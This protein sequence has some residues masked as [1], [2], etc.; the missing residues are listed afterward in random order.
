[1]PIGGVLALKDAVC[2]NAVG[3]DIGCGMAF[4]QTNILSDTVSK[5]GWCSFIGCQQ[6]A[7]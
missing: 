2:P 1:M 6:E 7:S 4:A 5:N 3:V